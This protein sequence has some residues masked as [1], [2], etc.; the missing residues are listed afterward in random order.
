[1]YPYIHIINMYPYLNTYINTHTKYIKY[2][3][4]C[5]PLKHQRVMQMIFMSLN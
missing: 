2:I 4:A 3:I 5:G 1:M